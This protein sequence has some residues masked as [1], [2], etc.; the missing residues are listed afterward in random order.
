M[1]MNK[2][3]MIDMVAARLNISKKEAATAVE[4]IFGIVKECLKKGE[5]I[6]IGGFGAFMVKERAARKGINPKSQERIEIAATKVPA[7]RP[8]KALKEL[9]K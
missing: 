2:V 3:Q 6:N 4:T 8:S 1:D 9:I 7:F 5:E